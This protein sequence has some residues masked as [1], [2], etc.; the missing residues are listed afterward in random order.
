MNSQQRNIL[1]IDKPKG[2]T[3]FD[4]IRALR[5]KLG[6]IKMGHAGTLDPL[7][8]GLMLVG[9]GEG[10]KE[11]GGL[12][13][14]PKTYEAEVLLGVKTETGDLEGATMEETAVSEINEGEVKKVL[15]GMVG[16]LL[17]PVPKYS[18][19]KRRVS[20]ST[21]SAERRACGSSHQRDG[22][23]FFETPYAR[24]V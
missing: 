2:I 17:L 16:T 20:R 21:K 22:S 10:T 1:L 18:A 5:K 13:G 7:A 15:A 24:A 12:L 8:T 11:L 9:V 3:S 4:V 14:L 19:V 6:M 23:L